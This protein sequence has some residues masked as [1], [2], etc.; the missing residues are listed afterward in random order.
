M[1][2]MSHH[3][4]LSIRQ[5]PKALF[6][7]TLMAGVVLVLAFASSELLRS[8]LPAAWSGSRKSSVANQ[9]SGSVHTLSFPYYT[10][11]ANWESMLTL[12]NAARE[13]LQVSIKL[14]SLDG[15]PLPLQDQTLGPLD[16]LSLR[17]GDLIK[18]GKF[19]EGSLEVSFRHNNGM[20]L[21][22]QLT[23]ANSQAGISFDMEPVMGPR[24]SKLEALWW[25]SDEKMHGQFMLS[26]TKEQPLDIKVSFDRQGAQTPAHSITLL[27]HQTVVL[28]IDKI[29]K[30]LNPAN[31]SIGLTTG[32][33]LDKLLPY[34]RI[35]ALKVGC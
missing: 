11:Q 20:A 17:L 18:S 35:E 30:E 9:S 29:V 6:H 33:K 13:V 3:L 26:N 19:K 24:S 23:I 2:I 28:D 8:S 22:P 21:G 31:N 4:T 25:S 7:S 12:N 10:T 34:N 27:S 16:H 1:K 15:A 32:Q 14:Y 5:T